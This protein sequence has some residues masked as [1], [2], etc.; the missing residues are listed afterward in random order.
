MIVFNDLTLTDPEGYS[1]SCDDCD[2]LIEVYYTSY[3]SVIENQL[4]AIDVNVIYGSIRRLVRNI[5]VLSLF[6]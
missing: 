6:I 1:G 2:I 5:H 4:V 3:F